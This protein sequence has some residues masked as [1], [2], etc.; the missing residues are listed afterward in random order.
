MKYSCAKHAETTALI[1][2][3]VISHTLL[4]VRYS[5]IL[6]DSREFI[7]TIIKVSVAGQ[8]GLK[9]EQKGGITFAVIIVAVVV[10]IVIIIIF[11]W[12]HQSHGLQIPRRKRY[13]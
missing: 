2:I 5:L 8:S 12:R 3:I 4:I 9:P 6:V 11:Y 1:C 10:V 13:V 7:I